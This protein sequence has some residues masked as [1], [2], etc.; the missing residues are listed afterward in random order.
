[1]TPSG[2]VVPA[3]KHWDL[4]QAGEGGTQQVGLPGGLGWSQKRGPSCSRQPWPLRNENCSWPRG[5]GTR[6]AGRGDPDAEGEISL[7]VLS[8]ALV[9]PDRPS[10]AWAIW[11]TP[12]G[13]HK[14]VPLVTEPSVNWFLDLKTLEPNH[15]VLAF[16]QARKHPTQEPLSPGFIHQKTWKRTGTE[17]FGLLW[18]QKWDSVTQAVG[19]R[20]R[21]YK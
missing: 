12:L 16:I 3:L 7:I 10:P 11:K 9:F 2:P 21:Y 1:M 20:N 13:F 6:P 18:G 15:Y 14:D 5:R 8:L 17:V 19:L 4:G